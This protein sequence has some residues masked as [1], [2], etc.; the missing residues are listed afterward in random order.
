M[1]GYKIHR[2]TDADKETLSENF[3]THTCKQIAA[4]IG[5]TE[6]AVKK[7]RKALGIKKTKESLSKIYSRPNT[8]Q[9]SKGTLPKNTLQDQAITERK[10]AKG[11]VYK[12]IRISLGKWQ[13]L[14][15]YNWIAAGNTITPG[16][17][18]AF[19]NGNTCDPDVN[20]LELISRSENLK[21]NRRQYLSETEHRKSARSVIKEIEKAN[22]KALRQAVKRDLQNMRNIVKEMQSILKK[23]SSNK[24]KSPKQF[25]HITEAKRKKEESK[26]LRQQ[27]IIER[28]NSEA[29]R[30]MRRKAERQ[31][32]FKNRVVDFSSLVHVKINSKTWLA[33]KPGTDVKPLLERYNQKSFL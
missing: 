30:I 15:I 14:H 32:L 28:K 17:V 18:L 4:M 21:R 11:N 7:M 20:N 19:K 29:E 33:V 3:Q 2:W 24:A 13:P 9:F 8:G 1:K 25:T 16:H 27:Q 5:C 22:K 23:E 6:A 12:W 26:K 31:P 10:D